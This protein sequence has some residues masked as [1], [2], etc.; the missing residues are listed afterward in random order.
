MLEVH[1]IT[2]SPSSEYLTNFCD[3]DGITIANI[4]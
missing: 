1:P 2:V 3:T 4:D